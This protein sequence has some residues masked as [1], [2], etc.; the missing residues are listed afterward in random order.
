MQDF[1]ETFLWGWNITK[2]MFSQWNWQILE[3]IKRNLT[4]LTIYEKVTLILQNIV[5]V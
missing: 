4:E 1:I 5:L 2:D 3:V